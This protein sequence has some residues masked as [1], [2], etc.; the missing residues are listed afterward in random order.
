MAARRLERA[1]GI[2]MIA[3]GGR[4]W[5]ACYQTPQDGSSITRVLMSSLSGTLKREEEKRYGLCTIGCQWYRTVLFRGIVKSFPSS[6]SHPGAD[7]STDPRLLIRSHDYRIGCIFRRAAHPEDILESS[8]PALGIR[9]LSLKS[10][11]RGLSQSDGRSFLGTLVI[12]ITFSS[13][14]L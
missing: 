7:S 10:L 13:L 6:P 11:I 9:D 12:G 8:S 14:G 3:N 2:S 1:C 5:L 4:F